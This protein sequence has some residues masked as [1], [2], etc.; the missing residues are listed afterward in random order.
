MDY[1]FIA[2]YL[3]Q[4]QTYILNSFSVLMYLAAP[5]KMVQQKASIDNI[6][7]VLKMCCVHS[8]VSKIFWQAALILRM[9]LTS[10]SKISPV[11]YWFNFNFLISLYWIINLTC[12]QL[13]NLASIRLVQA[14][15]NTEMSID[16]RRLLL[17]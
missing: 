1:I 7:M 3:H 16:F 15:N 6:N 4:P 10:Q 11:I 17:I 2:N 9:V 12:T 14:E 8:K 5:Q 13:Y